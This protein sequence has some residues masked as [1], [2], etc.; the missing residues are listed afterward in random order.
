M[1]VIDSVNHE[2]GT[3][4]QLLA[5]IRG[6]DPRRFEITVA[7]IEDGEPLRQLAPHAL[8]LVFP[9]HSVFS[10]RGWTQIRRLRREINRLQIDIVHAFMIRA[11]ILGVMGARGSVCKTVLTSRRN[12]GHWYTPLYVRVFRFLNR[13]TTRIVAN[14]E[15]AK[16]AAMEIESAPESKIDVLYNGVDSSWFSVAPNLSVLDRM[17][18]ARESR[19]LGIVAN[20]RP[21]KD[22]EMFLTAAALIAAHE[23]RAVFLLVGQGP[24]REQL[25]EAAQRLGIASKIFFTD[26]SES[27]PG[28]LPLMEVACLSSRNESFSNAI[29]EYMAAGLPVVATDVG[30]NREAIVEGVTGLLTPPEDPAAFAKAVI[31]LLDNRGLRDQMGRKARER[32]R[33]R[34]SMEAC[35]HRLEK[36]YESLVDRGAA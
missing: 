14:S 33:E 13:R 1:F 18:I 28:C 35:I 32:C 23:P 29:L 22:L 27:V 10:L 31:S 25:G 21:V 12:V 4:K 17:G 20:Y 2:A 11:A 16:R 3:E 7:C 24:L 9:F 5:T 36:Y 8:P 15:S 19:I 26:G 6:L 34:F 30:G